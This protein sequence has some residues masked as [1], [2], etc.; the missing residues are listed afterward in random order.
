[1]SSALSIY[2]IPCFLAK[3]IKASEF[4]SDFLFL[5]CAAT[6]HLCYISFEF[7]PLCPLEL[8][9]FMLVQA[10][11]SVW[12]WQTLALSSQQVCVSEA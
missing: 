10:G 5:V 7:F 1:M 3:V 4:H 2:S 11:F 8:L 9:L 6:L 12:L